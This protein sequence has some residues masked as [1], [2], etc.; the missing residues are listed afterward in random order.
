MGYTFPDRATLLTG[1]PKQLYAQGYAT[2]GDVS[3]INTQGPNYYNPSAMYPDLGGSGYIA[4]LPLDQQVENVVSS[5]FYT[6]DMI[7]TDTAANIWL[8]ESAMNTFANAKNGTLGTSD[9]KKI[10]S[11]YKAITDSTGEG[12]FDATQG[13]GIGSVNLFDLDRYL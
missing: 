10:F 12:F 6:K 7:P 1:P 11:Y 9:R 3:A 5:F 4:T 8:D 13:H 2:S